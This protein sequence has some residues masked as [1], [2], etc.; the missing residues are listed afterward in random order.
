[1]SSSCPFCN[2]TLP[3]Q[4]LEWHANNHLVEEEISRDMELAK[5][6]SLAHEEIPSSLPVC[7]FVLSCFPFSLRDR[8]MS[9]SC[10]FCNQTLPLQ[11][12][13]WHANNHLV[14][15]EISRDME[16]AKL[17]SLAHEEIPSS[18]PNAKTHLLENELERDMEL[19]QLISLAPEDEHMNGEQLFSSVSGETQEASTSTA[20]RNTID[21]CES[22]NEEQVSCLVKLQIRSTFHKVE[23]GLMALLK[24]CLEL[25]NGRSTTILSGYVDHFQTIKSEDAGWGCG[26][27]NIQMLSSH[28]ITHRQK[29]REIIFGGSGFVP[30][31]PSLQ[32]WLEIAW[33]RGFD[34]VGSNTFNQK[35]YG[36]RE[37]IGTTE[38]A[39]LFRYF[40]LRAHIVDFGRKEIPITQFVQTNGRDKRKVEHVYGPMDKFLLNKHHGGPKARIIKHEDTSTSSVQSGS[41]NQLDASI[42]VIND[43]LPDHD[44]LGTHS[45][46][47][48]KGHQVLVDWVWKYFSDE[49]SNKMDTPQ[50]VIISDKTPLY[51]QHF[52]HSRTIVGIQIQR[53]RPGIP[54][55]YFLL[56]LDP[57]H[58]TV[59]LENTLR[60]NV[61]WQR[62]IKRGVHTLKK[63]QYQVCYVDPGIAQ[64]E[65][66]EQLKTIDSIYFES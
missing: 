31:I 9:S 14:E 7:A 63:P 44:E 62:I 10:P 24:K 40:G 54:E 18:L 38:C 41:G 43:N 52:G 32:R 12:L 27:R 65:E 29:V 49:K 51:F 17:I 23:G 36:S 55:Q 39:A 5:L 45:T 61:G 35:I 21:H 1:M 46:G 11:E 48:T 37:W 15:E 16:L 58:R 20:S 50:R 47:M 56:V 25:E 60:E 22:C 34:A 4:E 66:M 2:Q 28:L 3:L 19:A 59:E 8:T 13:E 53:Q 42:T 26:W 64:V 57:G 33:K 6:I 30:D